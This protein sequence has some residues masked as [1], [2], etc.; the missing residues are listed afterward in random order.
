MIRTKQDSAAALQLLEHTASAAVEVRAAGVGASWEKA[1][2]AR[3]AGEG[4]AEY[5]RGVARAWLHLR[6]DLICALLKATVCG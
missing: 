6:V 5:A 3:Y 2:L 1:F 4:G